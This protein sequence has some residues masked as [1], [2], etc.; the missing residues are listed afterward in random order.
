MKFDRVYLINLDIS[1]DRL[2]KSDKELKKLGG[3]FEKYQR[4]PGINGKY[5]SDD[6]LKSI[7][8]PYSYY[9]LKNDRDMHYQIDKVGAIGCSL[10]HI[11]IWKD[12]IDNN[13]QN[14]IIFEDDFEIKDVKLFYESINNIPSDAKIGYLN[15]YPLNNPIFKEAN[16]NWKTT[17][18]I[19]I[20]RTKCYF[21]NLELV[22]E[23][24]K[25]SLPIDTHVDFYINYF[26]NVNNITRYYEI[27]NSM[28]TTSNKSTI[29]HG[30]IIKLFVVNE[31]VNSLDFI[32]F[33]LVVLII[34]IYIKLDKSISPINN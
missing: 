25:K 4:I 26:C 9:Y 14:A 33:M 24:I 21:I 34:W 3:I 22:K 1:K 20:L 16:K 8:T 2:V 5:L 17:D 15:Y 18:S 6:F 31:I 13:Y 19:Y 11:K 29:S 32:I 7:T 30:N 27:N 12:M 28:D 23:L 10:S